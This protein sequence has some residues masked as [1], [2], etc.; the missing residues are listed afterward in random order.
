[1]EQ[2]E[3][4]KGKVAELEALVE[5][6]KE[7][8]LDG[9]RDYDTWKKRINPFIMQRLV[10]E[11]LREYVANPVKLKELSEESGIYIIKDDP[12]GVTVRFT[13]KEIT[14]EEKI[15]DM[16]GDSPLTDRKREEY[17]D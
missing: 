15:L 10:V 2:V 17:K 7:A 12:L 16:S 13:K 4:L 14:G 1:M 5:K 11:I 6:Q 8:L 3:E 9:A